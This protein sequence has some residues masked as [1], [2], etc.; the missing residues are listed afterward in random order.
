MTCIIADIKAG[1]N[2][3]GEVRRQLN[4]TATVPLIPGGEG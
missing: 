3:K 4:T 2:E 1:N